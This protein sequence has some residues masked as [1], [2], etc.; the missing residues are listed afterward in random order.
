MGSGRWQAEERLRNS[1]FGKE[2]IEL[3][4]AQVG[5]GLLSRLRSGLSCLGV[6]VSLVPGY[7]LLGILSLLAIS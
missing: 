5:A 4:A 6:D 7:C 2:M 3:L 1:R